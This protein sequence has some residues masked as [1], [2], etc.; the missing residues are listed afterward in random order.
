[1]D[2]RMTKPTGEPMTN[3]YQ[4]PETVPDGPAN[5]DFDS[6]PLT[7]PRRS[8]LDRVYPILLGLWA[9]GMAAICS[10]GPYVFR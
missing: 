9:A 7:V 10:L 6:L 3:P 2:S 1:M 8:R 4:A 5:V